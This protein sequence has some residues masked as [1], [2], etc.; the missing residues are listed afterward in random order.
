MKQLTDSDV[1][2]KN[3]EL[4]AL[5]RELFGGGA[6]LRI[7]EPGGLRLAA[8][9][10]RFFKKET[11][12]QLVAN[13]RE[14]ARLSSMPLCFEGQEGLEVLSGNHRVQAA[15]Q[16]GLPWILVMVLLEELD[17]SRRVA[18]QLSHNALAGQD[19][20]QVLARLW[21][22]IEDIRARIYAGLS[23]EKVGEL[24]KIKL[25]TFTTPSV[26]TRTVTFAFTSGELER[27]QEVVEELSKFQAAHEVWVAE[28]DQ[29][30]RFFDALQK[31]KA[32]RKVKNASLAM[33]CM[34]EIVEQALGGGQ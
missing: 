5:G 11:F 21:S 9:N 7:V 26:A 4:D 28:L 3:V 25:V 22:R 24:E 34:I 27:V 15:V 29:Y 16:A 33:R 1:R 12:Q 20:E 18:I 19:D 32:V 8:E 17:E 13:I 2:K 6:T 10:A 23:S 30:Q 31:V 14:D